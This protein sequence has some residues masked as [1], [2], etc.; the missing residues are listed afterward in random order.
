MV[1]HHSRRPLPSV[2][3]NAPSNA[4]VIFLKAKNEHTGQ[5]VKQ[6]PVGKDMMYMYAYNRVAAVP[7]SPGTCSVQ[8]YEKIYDFIISHDGADMV[9]AWMLVNVCSKETNARPRRKK[10]RLNCYPVQ[11]GP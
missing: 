5:F 11:H 1:S 7:V 10:N 9:D 2:V 6:W 8:V 3:D 4:D